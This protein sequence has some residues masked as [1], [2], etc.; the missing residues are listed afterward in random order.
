MLLHSPLSSS[1]DLKEA[2]TTIEQFLQ[3]AT[4]GDFQQR[5]KMLAAFRCAEPDSS[6]P[7]LQVHA[8]SRLPKTSDSSSHALSR[9]SASHSLHAFRAHAAA[10]GSS[11]SPVA[12]LL[13]NMHACYQ[14]FLPLVKANLESGLAPVE[15]H[16]QV[17]DASELHEMQLMQTLQK[18]SDFGIISNNSACKSHFEKGVQAT[19]ISN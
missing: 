5:L 13:Q 9:K 6:N 3:A 10:L 17:R 15:K 2:A 4:L 14:Q 18:E 19:S 16:M 8:S 12:T 7:G 11:A 1:A